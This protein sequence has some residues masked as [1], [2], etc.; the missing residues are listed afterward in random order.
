[1]SNHLDK[2][3]ITDN[4]RPLWDGLVYMIGAIRRLSLALGYHVIDL[5]FDC[6]NQTIIVIG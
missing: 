2:E 1:M 6:C 5:A 3:L 4:I